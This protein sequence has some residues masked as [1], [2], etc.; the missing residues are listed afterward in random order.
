MVNGCSSPGPARGPGPRQQVA[1]HRVQLT[2][3]PPAE[4]A[5]ERSESRRRQHDVAEHRLGGARPQG[6]GI[7]DRVA[8]GQRRMDE[9]HGLV[10]NV[11]ATRRIA[12]IDVLVEE[13]SQS[14]MLR[15]G[16]RQHQAS[17]GHQTLVV[18][19]H[20]ETV[21]TVARYADRN[22]AFP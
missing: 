19:G 11:G 6:I 2:S 10:P 3:M 14:Q 15:Q 21:E 20:V 13:L 16:R 1:G 8:P 9:G 12:E 22:S 7:V 17:V 5:Q 4:A 18:E